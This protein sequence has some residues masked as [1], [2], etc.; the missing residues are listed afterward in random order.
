MISIR[1]IQQF[2]V[3]IMFSLNFVKV[4]AVTPTST[5]Q[6]SNNVRN[7]RILKTEE[8][9]FQL[10]QQPNDNYAGHYQLRQGSFRQLKQQQK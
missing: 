7:N 10:Q 2:F 6:Q 5:Y 4:K 9:Q 1:L 8:L 3:V